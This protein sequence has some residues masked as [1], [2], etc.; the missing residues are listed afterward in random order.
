MWRVVGPAAP[1]HVE[2]ADRELLRALHGVRGGHRVET[3]EVVRVT[4][5][6]LVCA[7]DMS[8]G[9][10]ARSHRHIPGLA[11]VRVE[12]RLKEGLASARLVGDPREDPVHARPRRC[13][14]DP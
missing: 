10:A 2:V 6:H 14:A 1:A 5:G 9:R 8:G 11:R 13:A 12:A 4:A 3:E 7:I